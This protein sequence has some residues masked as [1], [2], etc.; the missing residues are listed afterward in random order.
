MAQLEMEQNV[1]RLLCYQ[2]AWMIDQGKRP[3]IDAAL[4]KA[5]CTGYEQR[6]NDVAT[7]I[8]GPASLIRKGG[9]G[10]PLDVDLATCYLWGPSYTLQGG[11]VEILKNIIAQRGLGLPRS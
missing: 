7:K 10:A 8:L 9:Q 3:T 6:L 1:G 2:T 11:T 5:F 4:S